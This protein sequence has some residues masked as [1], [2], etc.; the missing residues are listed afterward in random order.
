MSERTWSDYPTVRCPVEVSLVDPDTGKTVASSR[1]RPPKGT[2]A[3]LAALELAIELTG[4]P[5]AWMTVR[6]PGRTGLAVPIMDPSFP[7]ADADRRVA[8][9]NARTLWRAVHDNNAE[10]DLTAGGVRRIVVVRRLPDAHDDRTPETDLDDAW[11]VG[12]LA[13]V[14]QRKGATRHEF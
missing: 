1:R 9:E 7:D 6:A 10:V 4:E 5:F 11:S 3:G 2:T 8:G 13:T 14:D 12:S